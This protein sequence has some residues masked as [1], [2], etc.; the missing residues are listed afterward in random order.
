M[1][2]GLLGGIIAWLLVDLLLIWLQEPVGRVAALYH[3]DYQLLGIG[4]YDSFNLLI[5]SIGLGLVGAW[6]AVTRHF[7]S[8]KI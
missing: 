7:F 8:T 3:S 4:L 1:I 2:Y 5:I 6:L